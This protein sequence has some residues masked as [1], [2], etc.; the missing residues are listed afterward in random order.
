MKIASERAVREPPLHLLSVFLHEINAKNR[1][2]MNS[3]HSMNLDPDSGRLICFCSE[4]GGRKD[5]KTSDKPGFGVLKFISSLGV[6]FGNS[7][8]TN[9]TDF[10]Q[11]SN[12]NDEYM[13]LNELTWGLFPVLAMQ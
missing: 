9:V 6:N 4:K 11:K 10:L 2:E 7:F 5:A 12:K 13:N 3:M 8:I 1:G